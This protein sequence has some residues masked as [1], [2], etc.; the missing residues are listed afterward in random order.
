VDLPEHIPVILDI[1]VYQQAAFAT[2]GREIW[3]CLKR[4]RV[5]KNLAF[6]ESL[7]EKAV[8]QYL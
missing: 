8:E 5:F 7:T 6:Y 1:D 2:D 3:E 4:L